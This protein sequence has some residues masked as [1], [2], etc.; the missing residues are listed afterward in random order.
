ML[1]TIPTPCQGFTLIELMI[2]VAIIGALSS[3]AIPAYKDYIKKSEV[4][5]AVATMRSLIAPAEVYVLET[6]KLSES[7]ALSDLGITANATSLG[8][9]S[10]GSSKLILTLAKY[11]NSAITLTRSDTTG[12]SCSAT[13]EAANLISS[14]L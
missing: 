8:T 6:G 7:T 4:A 5:A 3:M 1:R 9:I 13:G 14:C 11:N 2:V 12:W 10:V